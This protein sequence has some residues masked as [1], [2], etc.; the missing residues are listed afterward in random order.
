MLM[1]L[2]LLVQLRGGFGAGWQVSGK[3]GEVMLCQRG[4]EPGIVA[5]QAEPRN[6]AM[7]AACRLWR[8]LHTLES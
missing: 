6:G 3:L 7:A 8:Q 4:R 5:A 1:S 2:P